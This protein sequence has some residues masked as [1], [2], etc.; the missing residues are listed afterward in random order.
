MSRAAGVVA[1]TLLSLPRG[2]WAQGQHHRTPETPIG[3]EF[4]V[5]VTVAGDQYRPAVVGRTAVLPRYVVAWESQAQD[6]SG[7]GVFGR[8]YTFAW[9]PEFR[10]NSFTTGDQHQPSMAMDFGGTFVVAWTSN[11]DGGGDGV[12]AQ[13]FA[14]GGFPAGP[15]FRVNTFT[16]GSQ[17]EPQAAMSIYGDFVIVWASSSGQDGDGFGVFGQRFSA[18]GASLG[19]EFRV[20]TYTTGH[21]YHPAVASDGVGN[22]VVAW[23][24]GAAPGGGAPGLGIFGRRYASDGQPGPEF[25][26]ESY[27]TGYQ[28]APAVAMDPNG[29]FVVVWH[30]DGEDGSD[31]GIFGQRYSA[32][33][34]PLGGEF[35][36]NTYTT[37]R[38][39]FPTVAKDTLGEAMVVWSSR[40]QDGSGDGIYGQTYLS[41]GIPFLSEF[42]VNTYTTANQTAPRAA[43]LTDHN[44]LVVWQSEGQDSSGYGVFG[45]IDY[46][47]LPVELMQ[48]G[49][50]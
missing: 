2:G 20:N 17:S 6:G 10:V 27:T 39:A 19:P 13:G 23:Q 31:L 49:V 16:T 24:D 48:F 3:P 1:V 42:R 32:A 34:T 22:F 18:S 11:Q 46:H 43:P 35:R 14:S 9:G 30:S 41:S 5:N 28:G 25:H 26:V 36:T 33:G 29:Q 44:I 15:E 38:Q 4:A 8:F 7:L 12:F 45:Q 21:Q 40:G 37:G 47:F 50:E